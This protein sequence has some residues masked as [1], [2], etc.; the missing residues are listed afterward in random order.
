MLLFPRLALAFVGGSAYSEVSDQLWLF[1]VLGT[2]LSMLQLLVYAVLARSGRRPVLL[3]WLA[4]SLLIVGGLQAATVTGLL[5]T[6]LT[7]DSLL[8]LALLLTDVR[9]PRQLAPAAD[10]LP[11]PTPA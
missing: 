4:F 8:L 7:V 5:T 10:D 11:R 3:V 2:V 6:V 9:R 1:A